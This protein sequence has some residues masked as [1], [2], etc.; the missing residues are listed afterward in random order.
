MDRSPGSGANPAGE[1]PCPPRETLAAARAATGWQSLFLDPQNRTITLTKPAMRLDLGGIAKGQAADAMLTAMKDV[2]IP[3][4]CITA[5]GDIRVG[6]P[7]IAALGWKIGIRTQAGKNDSRFLFLAN[8]GISTSGDLHQFIEI[9]GIRYSHIID[10]ATGLGLTR[11]V[12]ATVIAPTATVSDA[13][14]TACC[15][16]PGEIAI[17]MASAA[18][19]TKVYLADLSK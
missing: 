16:A 13:V 11:G 3:R 2:G 12:A 19:A 7:P 9:G 18:G 8:C 1:K 17:A 5:G 15:V 14:A 10:P 4:S 6:D